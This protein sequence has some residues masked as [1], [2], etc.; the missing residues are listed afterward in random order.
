[1]IDRQRLRNERE[2]ERDHEWC[3][4]SGADIGRGRRGCLLHQS[5][6]LGDAFRR[7]TRPGRGD[8][9]RARP[10][11]GR[12][13]RRRRRLLPHEGHAGFDAAA[14]RARPRQRPRQSAQRQEGQFRH[15]QH[16]RPACDLSHRLQRPADLRHRGAGAADVVLGADLAGCEIRCRRWRR[17]DRRGQER[18]GADRNPDPARRYR[19]ERGRRHRPGAGGE[20]ARQLFRAGRRQ[21]RQGAA[22]RRRVDAAADDRQRAH[23]ARAG[24]G[25][26]RSPARPA[27]R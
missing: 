6:H 21:C 7:R 14:S 18:A 15:R 24:A 12:G 27:A 17:R 10:V 9:L 5:R 25:R 2:G 4:K 22:Q 8:A 23:R 1:M 13:D 26:P 16:R 20:P 3:G 11:R 19:L